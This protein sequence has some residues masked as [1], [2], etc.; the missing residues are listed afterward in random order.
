MQ[1]HNEDKLNQMEEKA[2]QI[3]AELE[4]KRL[5]QMKNFQTKR[6]E[7]HRRARSMQKRRLQEKEERLRGMYF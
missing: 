3:A 4:K 5:E 7:K 6:A 2:R 1:K